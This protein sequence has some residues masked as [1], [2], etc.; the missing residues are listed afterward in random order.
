MTMLPPLTDLLTQL[1]DELHRSLGDNLVRV[2]LYGSQARGDA[3]P[4]SDADV[5]I[6]LRRANE[7][8]NEMIHHIAYQIM[9]QHDF[10]PVLT[11]NIIDLPHYTLLRENRSSYLANVER[12][13]KSLW[14]AT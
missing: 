3:G 11:L 4:D 13:G 7:S 5:L 10:Q 2:T 12:E 9:W 14:P 1:R 8:Q 6:I